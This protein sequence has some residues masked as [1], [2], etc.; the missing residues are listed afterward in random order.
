MT[1]QD[2]EDEAEQ[3]GEKAAE[4]GKKRGDIILIKF[5]PFDKCVPKNHDHYIDPFWF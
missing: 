2:Y 1:Q 3:L 5:Y 4:V